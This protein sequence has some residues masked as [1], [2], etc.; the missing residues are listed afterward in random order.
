MSTLFQIFWGQML[1]QIKSWIHFKNYLSILKGQEYN[2]HNHHYLATVIQ[3]KLTLSQSVGDDLAFLYFSLNLIH[4]C[5]LF[6]IIITKVDALLCTFIIIHPKKVMVFTHTRV[7][8][9]L[10]FICA[11][12]VDLFLLHEVSL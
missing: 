9:Y 8:Q 12:Y 2:Y 10:C 1:Q 4:T 3:L 7:Q 6:I 11:K 5:M